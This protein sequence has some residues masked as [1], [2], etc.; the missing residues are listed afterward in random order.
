MNTIRIGLMFTRGLLLGTALAI[1]ISLPLTAHA[2]RFYIGLSLSDVSYSRDNVRRAILDEFNGFTVTT[3]FAEDGG[4]RPPRVVDMDESLNGLTLK[5]GYELNDY[6]SVEV[7]GGFGVSE[8]KLEDYT[9]EQRGQFG[10]I[11]GVGNVLSIFTT[12]RDSTL[13][14][15]NSYSA[16]LRLGGGSSDRLSLGPVSPYLLVG[17]QRTAFTAGVDGGSAEATV[18][19][20]A[21]G[22][23]MNI[24]FKKDYPTVFNIEWVEQSEKNIDDISQE[25]ELRWISAGFEYRF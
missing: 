19:G 4:E 14:L 20:N 5:L 10:T 1:S 15:N 24:R 3:V 21:Y 13:I 16:F 17:Y 22:A 12:P 11:P 6:F 23:G 2:E 25:L 18:D 9:E 7:R 8:A